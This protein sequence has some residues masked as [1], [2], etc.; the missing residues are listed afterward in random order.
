MDNNK[1][2]SGIG[3]DIIIGSYLM[4]QLGLTDYLKCRVLQGV[5]VT[6]PMKEP[7]GLL[8]QSDLTSREICGVVI[9]TTE[10]VSTK[11]ATEI[12]VK[13]LG[14]TYAKADLKQVA[15]N[16]TQLNAEE[17]NQLLRL[18]EY[19]EDLFDVT[20]GELYTETV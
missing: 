2:E 18:L 10:P 16:A 19:F 7:R 17:R 1:G 20:L 5:G 11:E 4:V 15:N 3:H 14:S 12:L 13:I 9:H 8:G 6:V